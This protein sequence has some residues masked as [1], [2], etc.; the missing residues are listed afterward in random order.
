MPASRG[1]APADADAPVGTP[2]GP[3]GT[4]PPLPPGPTSHRAA[5]AADS[6]SDAVEGEDATAAM[7]GAAAA[8]PA[9]SGATGMKAARSSPGFVVWVD[10][11][12]GGV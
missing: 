4:P 9:A 5:N 11:W 10:A 6:W 7:G 1:G 2:S 8:W 3:V 12:T